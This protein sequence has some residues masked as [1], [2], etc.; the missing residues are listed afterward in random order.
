MS[1]PATCHSAIVRLH[2]GDEAV[3]RQ[4]YE[5]I[6]GAYW[7]PVRQYLRLQWSENEA[8]AEELAQAFFSKAIESGTFLRY[9]AE[10]GTFR[11][12]LRSCLD[13]FVLNARNKASRRQ[14]VP[15]DFDVAARQAGPEELFHREFVR[16][17]FHLAVEDLRGTEDPLRFEIFERYDLSEDEVR[18]T[19][20]ELATQFGVTVVSITNYLAAMRRAF[21]KAVLKRLQELT[22]TER[23]FQA[24][25]RDI[26][27][28]DIP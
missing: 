27:G 9:A 8:D 6:I 7:Q 10:K 4:S 1:F 24:E 15:L 20:H 11:T 25:A 28:V 14:P 13:H 22:A 17:L 26:L 2:E 18:P 19:Y 21:R 16:S 12:Y 23:E 5:V 3:R